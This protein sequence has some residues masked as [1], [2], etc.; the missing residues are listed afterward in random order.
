[1]KKKKSYKLSSYQIAIIE[2]A[3]KP[4]RYILESMYYYFQQIYEAKGNHVRYFR[5]PTMEI[6]KKLG[7]VYKSSIGHNRYYVKENYRLKS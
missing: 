2:A 1:M 4:K 7:I 5:K 6:L 3:S